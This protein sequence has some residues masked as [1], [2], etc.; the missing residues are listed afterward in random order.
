[1]SADNDRAR[2]PTIFSAVL[3]PHRSLTRNGF[4]VLMLV[5]GGISLATGT[6]FLL[7]GARS[8]ITTLWAVSDATST[9]VMRQFY[10]NVAE[11]QDIAGALARSKAAV[12][13]QYGADARATVAA[14]QIIGVGDHRI[15]TQGGAQKT[16][17]L[18]PAR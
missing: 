8:V 5:L 9:A 17:S 10:E 1:M 2:E 12:L 6:A 3:T 14:F 4:L 7:A 18:G 11:G 13:Q 15:A 16:A